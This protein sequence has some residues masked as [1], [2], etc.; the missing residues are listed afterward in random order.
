MASEMTAP[1]ENDPGDATTHTSHGDSTHNIESG[2]AREGGETRW[3]NLPLDPQHVDKLKSS[4]I[5]PLTAGL[6]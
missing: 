4:G 1:R 2:Q 6:R 3:E 5:S